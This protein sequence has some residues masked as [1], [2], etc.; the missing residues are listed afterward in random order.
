MKTR[1]TQIESIDSEF[2]KSWLVGAT[3]SSC[4]HNIKVVK[5]GELGH[6]KFLTVSIFF[7]SV[8]AHAQQA[9]HQ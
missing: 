3:K 2:C 7:L 4:P 8:G 6:I 5:N 1:K 9:H